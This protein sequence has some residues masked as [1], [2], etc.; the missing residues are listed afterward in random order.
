MFGIRGEREKEEEKREMDE[1]TRERNRGEEYHMMRRRYSF[2]RSPYRS[3]SLENRAALPSNCLF[4]HFLLNRTKEPATRTASNVRNSREMMKAVK[5]NYKTNMS[6]HTIKSLGAQDMVFID[7]LH[8]F[9][10]KKIILRI[11]SSY[12]N[13]R[14]RSKK[15]SEVH[16]LRRGS[17]LMPTLIESPRETP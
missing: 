2:D 17:V 10:F 8:K 15:P 9:S 16:L 4:S 6:E 13:F 1:G 12:H 3:F 11:G 5:I 7:T 14:D